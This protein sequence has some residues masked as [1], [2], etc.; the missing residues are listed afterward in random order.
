M[1][2]NVKTWTKVL[3]TASGADADA[4]NKVF[5]YNIK[6]EMLNHGWTVVSS[7]N[8]VTYDAS[9]LWLSDAN[10]VWAAASS[11]HS[12][13]VLQNNSI[14]TGFQL[15]LD[16]NY[17]STATEDLN[18]WFSFV[19]FTGGST[20]A[21]PTA[22]DE[23]R[24]NSVDNGWGTTGAGTTRACNY[25]VSSDNQCH[26][27]FCYV[28]ARSGFLWIDKMQ[29]P[30]TWWTTPVVVRLGDVDTTIAVMS[31]YSATDGTF[32]AIVDGARTHM[33]CLQ[34]LCGTQRLLTWATY[35]SGD[36]DSAYLCEPA[37][38]ASMSYARLGVYGTLFDMWLTVNSLADL[39]Y[40]PSD[41]SMAQV[42]LGDIAIGNSGGAWAWS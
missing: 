2:A 42:V 7:S 5:L 29:N 38:I 36:Y 37:P 4:A 24:C 41:G 10:L 9:D 26:R 16:L 15:L 12:W 17:A 11:A 1:P 3:I 34:P 33:T 39:D 30:P 22:T 14:T 31:A 8:S 27:I 19:G 25:M 21:R 23:C 18:A 13:I 20:T 35:T 32:F 28:A 40:F 6:A